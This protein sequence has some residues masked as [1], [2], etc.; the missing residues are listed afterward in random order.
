MKDQ[1]VIV[2]LME[3]LGDSK[4]VQVMLQILK[5]P[6]QLLYLQQNIEILEIL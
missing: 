1:E 3:I 2:A 5:Q 4:Q 6:Q